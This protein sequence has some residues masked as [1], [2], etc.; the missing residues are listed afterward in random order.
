MVALGR[1]GTLYPVED[2]PQGILGVC[3]VKFY[4]PPF[5][6][7]RVSHGPI[8]APSH[9]PRRGTGTRRRGTRGMGTRGTNN[10]GEVY[11][12][13]IVGKYRESWERARAS[14][15]RMKRLWSS[16]KYA[17]RLKNASKRCDA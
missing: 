8:P 17:M 12:T 2:A 13:Y 11:L 3:V 10:V 5:H 14:E 6:Q 15:I 16:L 9:G 4:P 1:A 7:G